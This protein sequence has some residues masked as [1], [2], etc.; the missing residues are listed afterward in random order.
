MKRQTP[1]EAVRAAATPLSRARYPA[2]FC[3]L[4]KGTHI[5]SKAR[6]A[7]EIS[8]IFYHQLHTLQHPLLARGNLPLLLEKWKPR[9][10]FVLELHREW[11]T[12]RMQ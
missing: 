1:E 8:E 7:A 4:P 12:E 10:G 9:S 6:T 2:P 3:C 5:A 11:S